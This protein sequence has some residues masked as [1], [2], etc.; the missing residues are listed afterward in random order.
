M[1]VKSER[2]QYLERPGLMRDNDI[3]CI[4]VVGGVGFTYLAEVM[5]K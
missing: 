3:K 2:V 5:V 4:L 1:H